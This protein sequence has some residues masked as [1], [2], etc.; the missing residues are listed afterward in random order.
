MY[1]HVNPKNGQQAPLISTEVYDIIMN[2]SG[3]HQGGVSAS[4]PSTCSQKV[5]ELPT[6]QLPPSHS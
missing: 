5:C 1:E 3:G 2:V 6:Q 4:H